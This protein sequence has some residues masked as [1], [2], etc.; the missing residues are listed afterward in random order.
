MP[1][2]DAVFQGLFASGRSPMPVS[3]SLL[4]FSSVQTTAGTFAWIRHER[5]IEYSRGVRAV[6]R[7]SYLLAHPPRD[8]MPCFI[9]GPVALT[10]MSRVENGADV[11]Q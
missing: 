11:D 2:L 7:R 9:V 1:V 4:G 6:E 5:W 8:R 3:S 10:A